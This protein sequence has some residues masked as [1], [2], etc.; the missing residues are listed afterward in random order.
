MK[1][2]YFLWSLLLFSGSAFAADPYEELYRQYVSDDGKVREQ[3]LL[4]EIKPP[5]NVKIVK[6][7]PTYKQL[8]KKQAE[9]QAKAPKGPFEIQYA[10]WTDL[11][12]RYPEYFACRK[13]YLRPDGT[14]VCPIPN[15]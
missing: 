6:K 3:P 5:Y 14:M 11:Y 12:A 1:A 8:A 2:K 4:V 9:F 7:P 13:C 10:Y 15:K